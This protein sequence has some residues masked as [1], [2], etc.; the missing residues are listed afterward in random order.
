VEWVGAWLNVEYHN[1]ELFILTLLSFTQLWQH[2]GMTQ[3]QWR[4]M[5]QPNGSLLTAD[6]NMQVRI[7]VSLYSILQIVS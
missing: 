1:R 2:Q 5:Q 3:L 4:S 6:V 7:I